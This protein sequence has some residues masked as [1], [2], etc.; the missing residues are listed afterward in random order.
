MTRQRPGDGRTQ[1]ASGLRRRGD[2]ARHEKHWHGEAPRRLYILLLRWSGR[3][4][5]LRRGGRILPLRRGGRGSKGRREGS[6][7]REGTADQFKTCNDLAA[8]LRQTVADAN[9]IRFA[10]VG[11][12]QGL[13]ERLALRLEHHDLGKQSTG[14]VGKRVHW[15][16]T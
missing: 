5:L 4:L 15:R 7:T 1:R 14:G 8:D 3:I 13:L 16:G 10:E 12:L 6:S 9:K 2:T 11:L